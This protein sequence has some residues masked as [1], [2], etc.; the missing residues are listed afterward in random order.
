MSAM[1]REMAD[2]RAAEREAVNSG[3]GGVFAGLSARQSHLGAVVGLGWTEE[4]KEAL[5]ELG[6]SEGSRVVVIVSAMGY[7]WSYLTLTR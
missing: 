1:E 2:I 4:V 3:S 6:T 7:F 5:R